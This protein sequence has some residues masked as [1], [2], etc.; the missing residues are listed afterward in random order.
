MAMLTGSPLGYEWNRRLVRAILGMA[1][2]NPYV[3]N[4]PIVLNA[5][6]QLWEMEKVSELKSPFYEPVEKPAIQ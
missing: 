2:W 5:L 4:W 6:R 1:R 3:S